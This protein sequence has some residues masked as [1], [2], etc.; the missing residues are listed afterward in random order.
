MFFKIN[1]SMSK[2]SY[3]Y[4]TIF[5]YTISNISLY[6]RNKLVEISDREGNSVASAPSVQASARPFPFFRVF[7]AAA[8]GSGR[9]GRSSGSVYFRVKF[10]PGCFAISRRIV[11]R[12]I[13]SPRWNT[14]ARRNP[15]AIVY[16]RARFVDRRVFVGI[17]ENSI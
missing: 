9:P 7:R 6:R 11:P 15:G 8:F 16:S 10:S 3:I 1:F 13:H 14:E 17:F 2:I 5:I 12:T 4:K